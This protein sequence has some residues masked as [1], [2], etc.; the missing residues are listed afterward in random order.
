MFQWLE[1]LVDQI[2]Y[3]GENTRC[4]GIIISPIIPRFVILRLQLALLHINEV[5]QDKL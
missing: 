4:G 3:M 1:L 5:N 2:V